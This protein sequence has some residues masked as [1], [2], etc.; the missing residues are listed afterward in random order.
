MREAIEV[1]YEPDGDDWKVTVNGKGQQKR[2]KA[3]GLIA[4]RDRADQ[5][6]AKI[7][8][9]E[10]RRTVVHLLNGD[11]LA[12]TSAYLS[13]RLARPTRMPDEQPAPADEKPKARTSGKAAKSAK[14]APTSAAK[15]APEV[16]AP[17][18]SADEPQP[19]STS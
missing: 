1:N 8:P 16:P 6:V 19:A 10:Q 9:A 5:L 2:G 18:R 14:T 3:T 4:A 15:Q 11:A 13:A 17:T 7:E 12:F